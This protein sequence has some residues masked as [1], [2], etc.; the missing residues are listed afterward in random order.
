[1]NTN[2]LEK[3]RK[4]KFYGMFHAFKSSLES[5]KT[6]DYTADE[7]L[8][9]LVDAEWDDRN[10]R[11]V[12]RQ[13][14][15]ARFR[16]KAMV[17]NIHYHADRSIDRNQIMRLAECSF[18][19]RNENLLIT[20]ST[21]I[22]K[23]YVASAIG[24]QACILGYR[25]MYA[26]TPKLFAKL[27]MAKADGSYIKEIT[28]IERQQLLILDDF[29]IQ[30]FDAQSRAALMEIIEDRHGKTSLIITSQ[31]PVS[32]WHEVIGEKTIADAILDRIVHDA[33]RVELKGES[34]RRK[35]KTELETSYE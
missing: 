19:G 22:G 2:T 10:N 20:G 26:S 23:S 7:L 9:H 15:Y 14:L 8:A 18:I 27:K 1:M 6:N 3:L 11:R 25:V 33:H 17:E 30:P 21:G 24:H 29:G 5:G 32:K 13:I 35:R 16:Y 28:K 12:E 31:L 4:L 34:M